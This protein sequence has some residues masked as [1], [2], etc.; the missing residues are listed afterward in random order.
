MLS[1]LSKKKPLF[2]LKF[3][4]LILRHLPVMVISPWQRKL[5]KNYHDRII[6]ITSKLKLSNYETA[7]QIASIPEK[8]RGFG[9]VK[10]NNINTAKTLEASLVA[11]L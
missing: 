4:V 7:C 3:V 6:E 8:I 2:L 11:K 10:E 9:Y 1:H 5:I